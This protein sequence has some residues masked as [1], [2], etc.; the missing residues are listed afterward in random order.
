MHMMYVCMYVCIYVCM[1]C[2]KLLE[3]LSRHALSDRELAL[4]HP[5]TVISRPHQTKR[6]VC[7]CVCVCVCACACACVCVCVCVRVCARARTRVCVC[8][9]CVYVSVS[10]SECSGF[11]T[12]VSPGFGVLNRGF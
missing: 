7:V 8:V 3:E 5:T 4:M 10:V 12:I 1:Q 2:S 11:A 6:C 9:L